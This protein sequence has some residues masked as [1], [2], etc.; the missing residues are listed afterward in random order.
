MT[1][2]VLYMDFDGVVNFVGSRTRHRKEAGLGYLRR[3]GV[4]ANKTPEDTWKATHGYGQRYFNLNWSAELVRKLDALDADWL[5]LTSWKADGPEF[6]DPLLGIESA[7]WMDWDYSAATGFNHEMKFPA[8]VADQAANPRPFVWVD[9]EAT[10]AFDA[11]ALPVEVPHLVL[12]PDD[13]VGVTATD[14]EA[15]SEFVAKH[16]DD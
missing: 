16:G 14:L 1:R 8:L 9:D 4:W 10:V 2:P 11:S 5:W 15:M 7:G 6:L 3:N 12:T 13:A